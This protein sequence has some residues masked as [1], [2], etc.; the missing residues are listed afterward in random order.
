MDLYGLSEQGAHEGGSPLFDTVVAAYDHMGEHAVEGAD[1]V[2]VVLTNGGV[3]AV[4]LPTVEETAAALAEASASQS[5]PVS[6]YTVG[7]GSADAANLA[8]LAEATQGSY[9]EAPDA[10]G[11]LDRLRGG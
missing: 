8:V 5:V 11:L 1:N 7:F 4:S 2:I 10:G 9:I 3:D 6:V